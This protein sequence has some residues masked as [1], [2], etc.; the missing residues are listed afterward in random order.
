MMEKEIID[1]KR[2]EANG[3]ALIENT[4]TTFNS[5]FFIDCG[6]GR[7]I[8]TDDI[9]LMD[10]SGWLIPFDL[11]NR[12]VQIPRTER[13]DDEWAEY[14][15]FAEWQQTSDFISIKFKKYERMPPY[16]G[17]IKL[18][19]TDAYFNKTVIIKCN[20]GQRRVGRLDTCT[21]KYDNE[22][23]GESVIIETDEG[24]LIEIYTDEIESIFCYSIKLKCLKNVHKGRSL[25]KYK[26][27]NARDCGKGWYALIDE[28]GEEFAYPPKL[29]EV[30][31]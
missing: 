16:S 5:R 30:I 19:I 11:V 1:F 7:E 31:Q 25:V 4:A 23:D 14:F 27:Y 10:M 21:S 26:I 13:W 8:E 29:F 6:E 15:C 2:K 9:Y 20:D 12:F 3:N 24:W 22:P 18:G 28:S 17:A